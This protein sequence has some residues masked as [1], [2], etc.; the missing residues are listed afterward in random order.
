M[1]NFKMTEKPVLKV[2]DDFPMG[3]SCRSFHI[4]DINAGW[5]VF[6]PEV[7]ISKCIGC[8]RCYFVC[9]DGAIHM[10][11]NKKAEIDYDFCKGCGV[12][13][14]E[15]KPNVINMVKEKK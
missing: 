9:P 2:L 5:R 4:T 6:K 10:N 12:C 13:A 15:C 7:D 11:E 14:F 3:A 1:K 8:F